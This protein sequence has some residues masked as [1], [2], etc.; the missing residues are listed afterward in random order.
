MGA[1]G[2]VGPVPVEA[3]EQRLD[4]LGIVGPERQEW[5]DCWIAMDGQYV[6]HA[7]EQATK[8][9]KGKGGKASGGG[10]VP[11]GHEEF[12]GGAEWDLPTN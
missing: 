10:S 3:M 4:R 5:L 1:M 11:P 2:G 12:G 7:N 8:A 6:T 9:S